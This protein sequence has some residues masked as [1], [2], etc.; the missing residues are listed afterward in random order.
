MKVVVDA[1]GGKVDGKKVTWE[2]PNGIEEDQTGTMQA[3]EVENDEEINQQLETIAKAPGQ[4]MYEQWIQEEKAKDDQIMNKL[5]SDRAIQKSLSERYNLLMPQANQTI[6]TIPI[7]VFINF[8]KDQ[9]E[10]EIEKQT[11]LAGNL[12][13][14]W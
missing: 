1:F 4:K 3:I 13:R 10:I 11:V 2:F 7:D 6:Q 9:D 8:N 12:S 14:Y 5:L